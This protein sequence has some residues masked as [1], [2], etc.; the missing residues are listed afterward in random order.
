MERE[1]SLGSK[2]EKVE[3][4]KSRWNENR[5]KRGGLEEYRRIF[6]EAENSGVRNE[7]L[8]ELIKEWFSLARGDQ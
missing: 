6:Q 4:L 5:I 7:F 1:N 2:E 3:E 8:S